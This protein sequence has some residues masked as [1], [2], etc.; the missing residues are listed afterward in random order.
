[1]SYFHEYLMHDKRKSLR[2][3]SAP[4]DLSKFAPEKWVTAE[5]DLAWLE[6]AL[7]SSRH[8]PIVP[9]KNLRLLRKAAPIEIRAM[10]TIEWKRSGKRNYG[11]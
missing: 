6:E 2:A 7:D 1:M 8:F 9:K 5:N 3:Y 4:Y 10:T 11:R